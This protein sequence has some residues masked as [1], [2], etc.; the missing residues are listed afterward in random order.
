MSSVAAAGLAGSSGS[1][2]T[3]HAAPR[4]PADS[5]AVASAKQVL[6]KAQGRVDT[7]QAAHSPSCVAF[8]QK[9][10]D[11]ASV[12]VAQAESVVST[13][14]QAPASGTPSSN[15]VSIIV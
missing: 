5:Q 4:A 2:A 9:G 1:T 3:A 12:A 10:V 8:D 11:A 15:A 6:A 7:D 13:Q 14:T